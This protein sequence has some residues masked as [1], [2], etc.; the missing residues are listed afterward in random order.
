MKFLCMIC[1]EKM[2]EDM[3]VADAEK[4]F[5]EYLEFTEGIK[6]A[7][8]FIG[9]NRLQPPDTA[10]T[11]RVRNG[12]V[13][14][15]EGPYAETKEQIG[16]YYLIEAKDMNEA[17]GIASRIPGARYGCVELRPIADDPQTLMLKL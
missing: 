2:M 7:G 6:S 4:H 16:G 8:N 5:Q 13:L 1:A 11:V 10:K 9:A 14:T 17:V 12:R 15:T 3:P